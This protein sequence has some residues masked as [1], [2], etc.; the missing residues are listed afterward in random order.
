MGTKPASAAEGDPLRPQKMATPADSRVPE[1]EDPLR[2][3]RPSAIVEER[4][5]N[6]CEDSPAAKASALR[7]V[8][9]RLRPTGVASTASATAAATTAASAVAT[10]EAAASGSGPPRVVIRPG[11]EMVPSFDPL[12]FA[13]AFAFAFPFGVGLMDPPDFSDRPRPRRPADAPLVDALRWCRAFAR[14]VEAQY[15]RDWTLGFALWNYMFRTLL[16]TRRNIYT[17]A[18]R[19]ADAA[20]HFSL[21]KIEEAAIG[22]VDALGGK[23]RDSAGYLRPV[24]GDFTKLRYVETLSEGARMLLRNIEHT[25]RRIPGTQEVRRSLTYL[26]D[27]YRVVYGVPLFITFSPA[28]KDSVLMIRMS[29]TLRADPVRQGDPLAARWTG[30]A[31]PRLDL[32]EA[33]LRLPPELV[34]ALLPSYEDRR[35][36]L[37]RDPLACVHGFRTLC[38]LTLRFLFGLRACPFCPGCA[39]DRGPGRRSPIL[40]CTDLLG[41]NAMPEGGIYGRADACV[42]C[43]EHQRS[44]ALHTHLQLFMQCLHQFASLAGGARAPP[45]CRGAGLRRGPAGVQE[46]LRPGD[47]RGSC[48]LERE[49]P[50]GGRER[51]ARVRKPSRRGGAAR[52]TGAP[53]RRRS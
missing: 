2:A 13:V 45:Q 26:T 3:R 14:R 37:A 33:E 35:T 24:N 32:D 5:S 47:P 8:V 25:T 50:P 42:M 46:L 44:D 36:L 7:S 22:L 40:P 49:S 10:E 53:P 52:A 20:T 12:F 4:S 27:S 9:S 19:S 11:T 28:E 39:R 30:A 48:G 29:R 15:R 34:G 43:F 21:E 16:N 38:R 31:T 6:L 41:S 1:T 17:H 51:V 23:F 18:R